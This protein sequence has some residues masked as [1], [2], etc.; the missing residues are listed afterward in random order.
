MNTTDHCLE[1]DRRWHELRNQAED[2]IEAVIPE[3]NV[4]VGRDGTYMP[5]TFMGHCRH[6]GPRGYIPMLKPGDVAIQKLRE[7]LW[8]GKSVTL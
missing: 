5:E 2:K 7:S 6:F 8:E 4:G 3:S 1:L